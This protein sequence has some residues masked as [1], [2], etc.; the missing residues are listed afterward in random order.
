MQYYLSSTHIECILLSIP[1]VNLI[2]DIFQAFQPHQ[3]V[4]TRIIVQVHQVLP[5]TFSAISHCWCYWCITMY[6]DSR[7]AMQLAQYDALHQITNNICDIELVIA[8]IVCLQT[9]LLD[10]SS[11]PRDDMTFAPENEGQ[12]VMSCHDKNMTCHQ[13]MTCQ[14][15]QRH[16]VP[17]NRMSRHTTGDTQNTAIY[18]KQIGHV[19]C[20]SIQYFQYSGIQ[21]MEQ[22]RDLPQ[23]VGTIGKLTIKRNLIQQQNDMGIMY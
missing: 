2:R 19:I 23:L 16:I 9:C 5:H 8:C 1:H 6:H 15:R 12:H 22:M 3:F 7:T 13:V 10:M 14:G 21:V 17:P 20:P 18:S 4:W 11:A